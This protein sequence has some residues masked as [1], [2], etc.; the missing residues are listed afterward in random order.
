VKPTPT[1]TTNPLPFEH[2]DPHRFEDLVRQ[3]AYGYRTWEVL[4]AIGRTG[5]DGG[6][7]I[8]G[9]ESV[10][11]AAEEP[12]ED[13]ETTQLTR[14]WLIQV[15]REKRFG[16]TRAAAVAAE[17]IFDEESPP[18][19]FILAVSANVS[20][21]TR[22]ALREALA[23][24][25]VR[26]VVVWGL[27]ELEDLLFDPAYDHLLFAYFGISLAVRKRGIVTDLR[28]RLAKKRQIFKALGDLD[29]DDD[30]PVLL[31]DPTA[32]GYSLVDRSQDDHPTIP[33]WLWTSFRH[34]ANPDH[35]LLISARHH[36][37]VSQDGLTY[38]VREECSHVVPHRNGFDYMPEHDKEACERR[39]RFFY[40]EVPADQ[41][42][43]VIHVG[44]VP[45]DD[46]LLVD[47]LGDAA[48]EPP[49]L[50]VTRDHQ[51][52]YFDRVRVF[53]EREPG[54]RSPLDA[55]TDDPWQPIEDLERAVMFPDPI[56]D[57]ELENP[58]GR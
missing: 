38:D 33:P 16:P 7:D 39:W 29:Q 6:V 13:A 49:H 48:H 14:V 23:E 19:G 18:H 43:W 32:P 12:D 50:L 54:R 35:V 26:Q 34:H 15:K 11:S 4:E 47:D 56:P 8:R 42:A 40:S 5:D 41:R 25:G 31:R 20:R 53:L 21:K 58:W 51:A 30:T 22:D 10:S 1:R 2:L 46:I 57:V 3:L 45:Y 27:G 17:A 44:F 52:G 55:P 9:V 37:W 36:A 28:Q 24:R